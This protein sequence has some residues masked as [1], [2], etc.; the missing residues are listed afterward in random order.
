M[1][2]KIYSHRS[3]DT[4]VIAFGKMNIAFASRLE[5]CFYHVNC[6]KKHQFISTQV[7]DI[8]LLTE[9]D[10]NSRSNT[11]RPKNVRLPPPT[12]PNWK[13]KHSTPSSI[14]MAHKYTI[15]F[16]LVCHCLELC[17]LRKETVSTKCTMPIA[18]H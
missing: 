9:L 11:Y 6:S 3:V 16:E 7:A 14:Q 1:L 2:H 15:T 12:M 10:G 5:L 18:N 13:L 8:I 4:E 17:G